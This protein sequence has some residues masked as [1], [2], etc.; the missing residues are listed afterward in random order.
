MKRYR[1]AVGIPTLKDCS[2]EAIACAEHLNKKG[3]EAYWANRRYFFYVETD[4]GIIEFIPYEN[5]KIEDIFLGKR[6]SAMFNV[7]RDVDESLYPG[8]PIFT[9]CFLDWVENAEKMN[10]QEEKDKKTY[11]KLPCPYCKSFPICSAKDEFHDLQKMLNM[12][13]EKNSKVFKEVKLVCPYYNP[14][15]PTNYCV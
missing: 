5:F 15:I 12:S 9:S 4:Y 10:V 7:P 3:I 11:D 8:V 6:Y 2:L 14:N 13:I 1:I